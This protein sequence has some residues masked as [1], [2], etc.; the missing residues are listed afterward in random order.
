M[1]YIFTSWGEPA[2]KCQH[3]N[4]LGMQDSLLK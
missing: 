2:R 4:E 1:R 3:I